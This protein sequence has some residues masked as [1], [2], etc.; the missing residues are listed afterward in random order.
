MPITTLSP[1][2]I[3]RMV[4]REMNEQMQRFL[5]RNQGMLSRIAFQI[6]FEDYTTDEL[7]DIAK[8]IA[9]KKQMTITDAAMDKLRKILIL[10]EKKLITE[11]AA[12]YEKHLKKLR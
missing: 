10:L 2:E 3:G 1:V 5:D 4:V 7:C 11:M 12:L 6:E 8:L 9:S